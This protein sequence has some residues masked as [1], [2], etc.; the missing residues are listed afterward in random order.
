[1]PIDITL[2]EAPGGYS[3][4]AGRAGETVKVA[5]REFLS[6]EDGDDF[7][8]RL[9]GFPNIVLNQLPV[10]KRVMPSQIDHML[11]VIRRDKT[12]TVY[13][14]ELKV[15]GEMLAKRDIAAGQAVFADDI[16][17][18]R[19]IKFE[20][21]EVPADAGVLYLFSSGWRKGLF[22]DFAPIQPKDAEP[23]E[24]NLGVQLGQFFTYLL[25]Q[26]RLKISD[27][28]WENLLRQGWFPFISLSAALSK[29]LVNYAQLSWDID[30]LLPKVSAELK[31][32]FAKLQAKWSKKGFF[33]DHADLLTRAVDR[34]NANDYVSA[35]SILY[36]RIEG[37]MRS[38]HLFTRPSVS[39]NQ[40][41]LVESVITP[42]DSTMPQSMLLLP[43]KFRHYL[44]DIYFAAFDPKS[45]SGVSRHTVAHGV[46]PQ[47]AYSEKAAA[48]GFLI[49][50]Q[51]SYYFAD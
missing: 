15:L 3:L 36:P 2:T 30:E 6:S 9:E 26:D 40:K 38:Y 27:A 11:A 16:A 23:R 24:Y 25:F 47:D 34:F 42:R 5:V 19:T 10:E 46:A 48:V 21:V 14:N 12:C 49:L 20:G 7:L 1:M 28:A 4:S 8:R 50:D 32:G 17:G 45:P 33:S 29:E 39:Q 51:L 44:A 22:Y 18:I 13:I 41:T 31:S 35:V 43:E 37:V